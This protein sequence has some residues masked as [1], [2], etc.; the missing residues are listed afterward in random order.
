MHPLPPPPENQRR[1]GML[2]S[3]VG[4]RQAA[5][6]TV[7]APGQRACRPPA[8]AARAGAGLSPSLSLVVSA[9][10][11]PAVPTPCPASAMLARIVRP[12]CS[13]HGARLPPRIVA[14]L[15]RPQEGKECR[16]KSQAGRRGLSTARPFRPPP[17]PTRLGRPPRVP[18]M[19]HVSC[20]WSWN[21]GGRAGAGSLAPP[22]WGGA[23]QSR[24]RRSHTPLL[25]SLFLFAQQYAAQV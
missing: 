6:V 12:A 3:G 16:R 25:S 10:L 1:L 17:W 14:R 7:A 5:H 19:G 8:A 23:S 18:T 9:A 24:R 2:R 20:L 11:P 4:A 22:G 13:R 21:A 15:A